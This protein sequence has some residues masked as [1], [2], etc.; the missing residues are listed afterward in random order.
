MLKM[1]EICS[2]PDVIA[3]SLQTGLFSPAPKGFLHKTK[4]QSAHAGL[5]A[6][7][8]R[9]QIVWLAHWHPHPPELLLQ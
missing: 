4:N 6:V 9:Q 3:G 7:S 8:Y 1:L 2:G 5:Q